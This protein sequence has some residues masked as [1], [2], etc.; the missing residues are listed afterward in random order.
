MPS[1]SLGIARW[2]STGRRPCLNRGCCWT[3]QGLA[4]WQSRHGPSF[5]VGTG[6]P[7]KLELPLFDQAIAARDNEQR[8]EGDGHAADAGDRHRLRDIG[9]AAEDNTLS[10][11]ARGQHLSFG[12]VRS[13]SVFDFM[14]EQG[15]HCRSQV[16]QF[17][18]AGVDVG[19]GVGQLL[20]EGL[21]GERFSAR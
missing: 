13:W 7:L 10:F 11:P 2:I 1:A 17:V 20:G 3:W 19:F 5:S 9:A 15:D 14:W 18:D 12:R 6:S 21:H 8:D 4:W 16:E